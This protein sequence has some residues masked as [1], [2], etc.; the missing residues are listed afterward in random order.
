MP[1]KKLNIL[2]LDDEESIRNSI[3]AYL[4]DEGFTVFQAATG[5]YALD[6]LQQYQIGAAIVDI[7]L[8]GIDGNTFIRRAYA[9]DPELCFVVHTGSSDYVLPDDLK[10]M[11]ISIDAVFI[12]PVYDLNLLIMALKTQ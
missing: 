7:R 9:I 8:P 6:L 5:E 11:G 10:S 2:V 3:G 4:E 12:K 1:G